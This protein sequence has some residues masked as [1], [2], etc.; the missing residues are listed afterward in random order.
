MCNGLNFFM[1]DIGGFITAIFFA[2]I[3]Q[4]AILIYTAKIKL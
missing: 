2:K 4:F 1:Y 3:N